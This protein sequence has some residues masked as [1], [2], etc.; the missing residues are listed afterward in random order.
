MDSYTIKPAFVIII[1]TDQK[2]L[3]TREEEE[4]HNSNNKI[5]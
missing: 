4:K 5:N 1:E 3:Q 2:Q